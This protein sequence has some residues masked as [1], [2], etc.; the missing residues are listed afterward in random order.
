ML[1]QLSYLAHGQNRENWRIRE[2]VSVL[3]CCVSPILQLDQPTN[4][5]VHSDRRASIGS[6]RRALI[7]GTTVARSVTVPSSAATP[8]NVER[9]AF[10]DRKE[11]CAQVLR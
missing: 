1:Y 2:S 3:E 11:Q 10:A 9:I 8:T 6:T 4:C 7:A 5:T